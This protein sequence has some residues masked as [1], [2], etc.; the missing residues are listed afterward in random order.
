MGSYVEST[1]SDG[2]TIKFTAKVS[3]W[4]LLPLFILGLILLPLYGLGLIFWIWAAIRY[5]TT[6]MAVTDRKI[7]AKTGFISRNTVELLLSKVESIRVDQ[8]ILGRMLNY[9]SIV[10]AGA[11]NPQAPIPGIASPLEFRKNFVAVQE[12]TSQAA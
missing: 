5:F 7:I 2:E 12:E 6:E 8:S 4:S 11:G 3:L 10:V 9:G 1:L